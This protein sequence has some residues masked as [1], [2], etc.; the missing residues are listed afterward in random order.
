MNFF[1]LRVFTFDGSKITLFF[2]MYRVSVRH[3]TNFT[4]DF[5]FDRVSVS[6]FLMNSDYFFSS[7][8][9]SFNFYSS[10]KLTQLVIGEIG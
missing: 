6:I 4:I 5:L 3:I 8:H 10:A 7:S 9:V 1:I 2:S